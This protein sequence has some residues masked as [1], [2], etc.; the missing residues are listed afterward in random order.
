MV[1]SGDGSICRWYSLYCAVIGT[2]KIT[3]RERN[4]LCLAPSVWPY[5]ILPSDTGLELLGGHTKLGIGPIKD[6]E[7]RLQEDIT[8]D[9]KANASVALEA[10]ETG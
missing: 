3:T 2:V 1:H 9:G 8:I 4:V 10:A 5:F 6:N 7:L